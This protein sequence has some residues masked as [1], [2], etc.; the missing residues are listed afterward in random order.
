M[1]WS[2]GSQRVGRDL[3]TE[4]NKEFLCS[5]RQSLD[6]VLVSQGCHSELSPIGWLKTIEVHSLP[7][8]EARGGKLRCGWDCA[9]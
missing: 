8:L 2:M 7:V 4:Q 6:T 3:V 1:L 9:L 5:G